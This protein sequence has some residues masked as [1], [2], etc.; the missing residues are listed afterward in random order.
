MQKRIGVL[1]G[2]GDCPGLNA[3]IRAVVKAGIN[4]HGLQFVGFRR[5]FEGLMQMD[6]VVLDAETIKGILARGGTILKTSNRG[7]PFSWNPKGEEPADRS[8]QAVRNL[9]KLDLDGLI[10]IG[11]DGSLTIANRL[12]EKGARI[13]G[14]P[15]TIDNDIAATDYTFGFATAVSIATEAIDRLHSTAESH[16]RV[17]ILEV[18]GRNAGWIALHSGI[19]GGADIILIPEI[20]Y[21]PDCVIAGIEERARRGAQFDI[22]VVAEGARRVGGDETYRDV[23]TRRLG[24]V[25]Y[26]VAEEIRGKVHPEVRVTV[27]GHVQ[28]GGSPIP[29]D[30]LLATRFGVAAARL[31][32]NEEFG[33]MVALRGDTI[34][35]VELRDAVASPKHVDPE[36]TL[37]RIA[38]SLGIS[39]GDEERLTS[40][41]IQT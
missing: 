3:V 18:M 28:R 40:R 19:S 4:D 23:A 13:I 15:K 11:G 8:G 21:D 10:V 35:P 24:G 30:R 41:A 26:T 6:T 20:D 2:G 32:A 7:D 39:F 33:K 27:L 22:I 17:M 12:S 14:V 36:G 38:R 29:W 1:T 34:Q 31:A 16:N 25:A 9:E 37:V 5:G